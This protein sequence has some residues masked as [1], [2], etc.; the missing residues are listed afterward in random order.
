MCAFELIS[1]YGVHD[2]A[3]RLKLMGL[4]FIFVPEEMNDQIND[5]MTDLGFLLNNDI[6]V[7]TYIYVLFATHLHHPQLFLFY[8]IV[9]TNA[10]FEI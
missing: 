1:T 6:F 7:I 3:Y 9:S 10:Y 4:Q 2:E 5:F 8:F